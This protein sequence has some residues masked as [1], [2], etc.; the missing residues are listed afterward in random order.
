MST[1]D[2]KGSVIASGEGQIWRN[3]MGC[4]STNVSSMT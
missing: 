3:E 4:A 2:N 1:D